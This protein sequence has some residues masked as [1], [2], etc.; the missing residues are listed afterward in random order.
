MTAYEIIMKNPFNPTTFGTVKR[1]RDGKVFGFAQNDGE[2]RIG[3]SV[4]FEIN[5]VH[6]KISDVDCVI[7]GM[8]FDSAFVK[9]EDG[10]SRIADER[11]FKILTAHT[12][13]EGELVMLHAYNGHNFVYKK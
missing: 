6:H 4:L 1:L 8:P 9:V 5:P 10:L 7:G 3:G 11:Y 13:I 12:F 2:R